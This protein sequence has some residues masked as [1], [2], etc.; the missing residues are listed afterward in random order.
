[1]S[2]RDSWHLFLKNLIHERY[3]KNQINCY[4]KKD[5]LANAEGNGGEDD[6]KKNSHI[7]GSRIV[8]DFFMCSYD[9]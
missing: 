6:I 3:F 5:I 9:S 7:S 1:M 4:N 8:T 2:G